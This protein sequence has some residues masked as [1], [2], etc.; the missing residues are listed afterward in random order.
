MPNHNKLQDIS[1]KLNQLKEQPGYDHGIAVVRSILGLLKVELASKENFL[2]D[3]KVRQYDSWFQKH[4]IVTS[5]KAAMNMQVAEHHQL[6]AKLY[7]LAKQSRQRIVGSVHFTPNY[8]DAEFT[9]QQKLPL[10]IDFFLNPEATAVTIAL[11]NRGAVRVLQLDGKLTHTASEILSKWEV[12]A[13]ISDQ[14]RLHQALWDS[15]E[16]QEVN[17][18]FYKEV[19]RFFTD[20]TQYLSKEGIFNESDAKQY[21]NKL[22]GRLLFIWFLR[23]KNVISNK[24][25]YFEATSDSNTYYATKLSKL[26]FATL[27]T[28]VEDRRDKITPY[29]NGG[30]FEESELDKNEALSFPV[31]YFASLFDFFDRYNFTTDES[32]PDFEQVAIDPEML[33]RIFENLLAEQ[34]TETGEQARKASG[35]FYTP[36]EIVDYM[37]RESLRQY[38]YKNLEG[39]ITDNKNIV[40]KLIDTSEQAWATDESNQTKH[41][42]EKQPADRDEVRRALETITIL[43]PA[44][45]SGAFPMG[46]LQL[47]VRMIRRVDRNL[48]EYSIKKM[49]LSKSIYGVDINPMAADISRLRAWLSLVVD[50]S[51]DELRDNPL[52]NLD[53]KFI[54]ANALIGPNTQFG[55]DEVATASAREKMAKIIKQFFNETDRTKKQELKKNYMRYEAEILQQSLFGSSKAKEQINTYHPFDSR[56]VSNF[57]ESSLMFAITEGFD[58]IIGNPP[59][60]Q[61]QKN[62]GEL[63]NLYMNEGYSTYTKTGDIYTLFYEKGLQL[64][65]DKGTLCYITSNKW[66]KSGYGKLLRKYLLEKV[67]IRSLIDLSGFNVFDNATVDTSIILVDKGRPDWFMAAKCNDASIVKRSLLREL[68]QN[69]GTKIET[70]TMDLTGQDSW[71]INT[72]E[73]INLRKKIESKGKR[74]KDWALKMNYGVKTG[75]NEAFIIDEEQKHAIINKDS[76]SAEII[77]PILRGQDIKQY[78]YK[79]AHKYILATGYK[80]DIRTNYPAVYDFIYEVGTKIQNKLLKVKGKGVFNRDDQGA[81]WWNLR[82]C[83]Y[84]EDFKYKKI[85][86]GNL[87]LGSQFALVDEEFYIGAPANFIISEVPEYLLGVLNSKIAE[88][89]LK[90]NAVGRNGGYYE[91][92]RKLVSTLPVPVVNEKNATIATQ[93]ETLVRELINDKPINQRADNMAKVDQLIYQLYELTPEEIQ[94]IEE[95]A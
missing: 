22:L 44:C 3:Q 19:A 28:P 80:T 33:G 40:D 5:Q 31:A 58:L 8:E 55:L 75:C 64:L 93:I 4:P 21:A 1:T 41:L 35:A 15:F 34:N 81:N 27:N 18:A 24:E 78:R 87:T 43:D 63:A 2:Q 36:R 77:K 60:I 17:K 20:L 32:T 89:Y 57:F 25:N 61:L 91:F 47:L 10:G 85:A 13:D 79:F 84:Y 54:S 62:S 71:Y 48:N 90:M 51:I 53:F 59:Y 95:N 16:L 65:S 73:E 46:M 29:L 45:G 42:F 72:K 30:L 69:E 11:S 37:C 83:D 14:E 39:K 50:E 70:A 86:W 9:R 82:A 26:F 7:W 67:R 23:K 74:L 68:V 6:Q 94:I 56:S 92:Q 38:L 66:L 76:R 12:A 52:P 88:H 49:F